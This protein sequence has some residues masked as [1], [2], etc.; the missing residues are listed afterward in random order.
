MNDNTEVSR[1]TQLDRIEKKLE[2]QA[3]H[4][5]HL[6]E[7]LDKIEPLLKRYSAVLGW[8]K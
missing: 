7:F 6:Q 8:K 2:K 5:Q 3:Q 4:L 1:E